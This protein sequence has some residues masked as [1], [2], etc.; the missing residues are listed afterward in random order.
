M[1]EV[2]EHS[3]HTDVVLDHVAQQLKEGKDFDQG[4]QRGKQHQQIEQET[5]EYVGVDE[6]G[7][8]SE[9]PD[10]AD[11]NL[12]LTGHGTQ[13]FDACSYSSKR[14]AEPCAEIEIAGMLEP[15]GE[16]QTRDEEDGIGR[17]NCNRNRQA[18][19]LRQ[20]DEG[21]ETQVIQE[22]EYNREN[23]GRRFAALARRDTKRHA[24]QREEHAGER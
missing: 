4:D 1:P 16:K 20:T 18:S 23:E 22:R 24:D 9:A 10:P 12:T 11:T 2:I 21:D 15:P 7:A 14:N 19:F 17:P 13:A 3:R 6:Q 5:V 8:Q